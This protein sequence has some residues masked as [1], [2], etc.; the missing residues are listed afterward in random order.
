MVFVYYSAYGIA[1]FNLF[2]TDTVL[3]VHKQSAGEIRTL[4]YWWWGRRCQHRMP[5]RSVR[6]SVLRLSCTTQF[7]VWW[8]YIH[9]HMSVPVHTCPIPD[10]CTLVLYHQ[11]F[12]I[13][14]CTI[15]IRHQCLYIH[16]S[17]L[18]HHHTIIIRH[19]YGR[20]F[21]C[22]KRFS[23]PCILYNHQPWSNLHDCTDTNIQRRPYFVQT[24][25]YTDSTPSF[26]AAA[27]SP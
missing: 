10:D 5:W 22:Y 25:L 12:Y 8:S 2:E 27:D 6:P 14:D 9:G 11:L 21:A 13:D 7:G 23:K 18:L 4:L 24:Y 3:M 19:A 20:T 1:G 15:W 16:H 17:P 26:T